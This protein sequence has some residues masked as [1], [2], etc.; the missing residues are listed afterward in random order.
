M[1]RPLT[2]SIGRLI[3]RG[4]ESGQFCYRPDPLQLYLSIVA[5][6]AHHLNNAATLS[7][8]FGADLT[9][10]GWRAERRNHVATII[11]RSVGA[12]AELDCDAHSADH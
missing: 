3:D 10:D 5:L 12:T 4:L 11:L 1:S 8:T 6:S 9:D 7:A 2:I